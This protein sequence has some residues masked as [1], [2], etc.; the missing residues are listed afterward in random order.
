MAGRAFP[1]WLREP[2]GEATLDDPSLC[3]QY[4]GG[5]R[6][7]PDVARQLPNSRQP[8]QKPAD[9][10]HEHSQKEKTNEQECSLRSILSAHDAERWRSVRLI[11][12]WEPPLR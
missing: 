6:G 3:Y 8:T 7:N 4:P 12:A 9:E 1:G 2:N 5:L 11:V 10:S